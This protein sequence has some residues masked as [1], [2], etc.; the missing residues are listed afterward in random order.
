MERTIEIRVVLELLNPKMDDNY[1]QILN[2]T[3]NKC[4][5]L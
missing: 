2:E 1:S 4:R 3:K 5:R